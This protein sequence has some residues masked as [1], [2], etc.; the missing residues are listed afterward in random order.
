MEKW[1]WIRIRNPISTKIKLLLEVQPL[2]PPTKF[3]GDPW[4]RSWDILRTKTVRTHTQTDR[5]THTH[6]DRQ[7]DTR[8]WP[9]DLAA[10]G[11]QVIIQVKEKIL[12]H[13]VTNLFHITGVKFHNNWESFVENITKEVLAFLMNHSLHFN[14]SCIEIHSFFQAISHSHQKRIIFSRK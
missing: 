11:A 13:L 12:W 4:T 2:L 14:N 9:Q 5:Q 1:S 7:T 10:Y 3:G 6:T 8:R